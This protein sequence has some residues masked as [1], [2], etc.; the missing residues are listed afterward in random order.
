MAFAMREAGLRYGMHVPA[1][2]GPFSA[3]LF[4]HG[5][6]ESGEDG[7]A[8]LGV[9]L[10]PRVVAGSA[11][12]EFVVIAPQKPTFDDLW[13]TYRA[14]L[15]AVLVECEA[16][17]GDR[18]GGRRIL[19]GL[20]QGGHGTLNLARSLRW[21]FSALAAVCGWMDG[22]EEEG[23][24]AYRRENF[25]VP[26]GEWADPRLVRERLYGIPLWLFHGEQDAI[27]PPARSAE[28]AALLP[29]AGFTVYEGVGHDSWDRAY[30]E[31]L[32]P[33][34]LGSQ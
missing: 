9:G 33:V 26:A 15:D 27:V 30:D 5:Y 11:W 7:T 24:L 25:H 20:S 32:L 16:E 31:P 19:T 2:A 6:G 17:L 21:D 22:F 8:Q 1:G 13:P 10:P 3:I 14:G 18:L 34:W 23:T 12:S 29:E 4:L 28:I